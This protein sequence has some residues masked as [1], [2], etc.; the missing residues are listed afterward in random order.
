MSQ[1]SYE[2]VAEHRADARDDLKRNSQA[3]VRIVTD[4]AEFSIAYLL[5]QGRGEY[6]I[7]TCVPK[8]KGRR[9][10]WQVLVI[11]ARR[12]KQLVVLN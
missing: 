8:D 5:R 2:V 6:R 11:P 1:R 3:T 9:L 12:V 4:D 7:A 10:V